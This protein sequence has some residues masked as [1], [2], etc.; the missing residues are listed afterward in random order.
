MTHNKEAIIEFAKELYLTP[1]EQGNHKYSLRDITAEM[2]Q[3]CNKSVYAS[4]VLHW[5]KKYGWNK[6]WEEG[7]RQGLTEAL[8]KEISDKKTKEE[9]FVEAIANKK[10]QDFAMDT[11]IKI[12]AYNLIKEKGFENVRDALFAF[13]M[14][15]KHTQGMSEV[16]L[17]DKN[18]ADVLLVLL[19]RDADD[20]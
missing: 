7:V 14:A 18:L 17:S 9:Q 19:G 16:G 4:T 10:R 15:M 8:A 12:W 11:N 1:D 2:Q 6:L 3:K 20:K 13:D 5:S